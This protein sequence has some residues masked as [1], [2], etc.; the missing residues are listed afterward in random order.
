MDDLKGQKAC[1]LIF[2]IFN[3]LCLQASYADGIKSVGVPFI[4][5]FSKSVYVHHPG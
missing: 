3:F 4:Q 1:L 5:N 2:L